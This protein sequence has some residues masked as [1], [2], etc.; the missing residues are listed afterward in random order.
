MSEN[1]KVIHCSP[2]E[3]RKLFPKLGQFQIGGRYGSRKDWE[4]AIEEVKKDILIHGYD[5]ARGLVEGVEGE[6]VPR[7]GNI[8]SCGYLDACAQNPSLGKQKILVRLFSSS[9]TEAERAELSARDAR[10][11]APWDRVDYYNDLIAFIDAS[12]GSPSESEMYLHSGLARIME[13][14]ASSIA[15]NKAGEMVKKADGTP[16]FI[17]RQ[18]PFQDAKRLHALPPAVRARFFDGIRGVKKNLSKKSLTTLTEEWEKDAAELAASNQLHAALACATLE[19]LA[20]LMPNSRVVGRIKEAEGRKPGRGVGAGMMSLKDTEKELQTFAFSRLASAILHYVRRDPRWATEALNRK[21]IVVF[22]QVEKL[23]TPEVE[24]DLNNIY[25]SV[26]PP[27]AAPA[28]QVIPTKH[29]K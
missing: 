25:R 10:T 9:L 20:A 6:D 2:T 17:N 14:F 19:D 23:L 7:S 4:R 12:G 22:R 24:E 13:Q 5:E 1:F 18:G 21:L 15:Y 8:R 16:E 27:E 11:T 28:P 29:K 3:L 26:L